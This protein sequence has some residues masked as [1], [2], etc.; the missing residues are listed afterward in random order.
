ME[1]DLGLKEKHIKLFSHWETFDDH[2]QAKN[3]AMRD[4]MP[5]I[6]RAVVYLVL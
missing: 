2:Q 3:E 1:D 6:S 5:S 4:H